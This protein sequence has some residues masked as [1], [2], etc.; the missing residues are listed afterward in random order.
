M[1]RDTALETCVLALLHN[2]LTG[3]GQHPEFTVTQDGDL[4]Q[5]ALIIDSG[6]ATPRLAECMVEYYRTCLH[7]LGAVMKR[8]RADI[9]NDWRIDYL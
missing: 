2:H 6:Y 1:T 9:E 7:E 5:V 3:P 8:R 4:Y